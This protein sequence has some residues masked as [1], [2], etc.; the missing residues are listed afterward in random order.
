MLKAI[1]IVIY[2]F[3]TIYYFAC[4]CDSIVCTFK[5]QKSIYLM[6]TQRMKFYF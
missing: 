1:N 4:A 5:H 3:T 2:L 6:N